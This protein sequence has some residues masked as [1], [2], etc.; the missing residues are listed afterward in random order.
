[1]ARRAFEP[2]EMAVEQVPPGPRRPPYR[3][4]ELERL[5]QRRSGGATNAEGRR[6]FRRRAGQSRPAPAAAARDAA[7]GWSRS[8]DARARCGPVAAIRARARVQ[9][10][11]PSWAADSC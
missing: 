3:L 4:E 9:D 7:R 11:G 1:M 8:V 6:S 2:G 5:G 10:R